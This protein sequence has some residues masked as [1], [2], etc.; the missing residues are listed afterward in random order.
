[1]AEA[2]INEQRLARQYAQDFLAATSGTQQ[3]SV[4]QGGVRV[5]MDR[6]G[7]EIVDRVCT[8]LFQR[9]PR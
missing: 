3:V 4:S 6:A 7:R 8:G 1:M 2:Y 5:T 9:H